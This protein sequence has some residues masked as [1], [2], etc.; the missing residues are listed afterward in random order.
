[1]ESVREKSDRVFAAAAAK[2]VQGQKEM[3][4]DHAAKHL[5][6]SGNTIVEAVRIYEVETAMGIDACADAVAKRLEG[7]GRAWGKAMD[8]VRDA[9]AAHTATGGKLVSSSTNIAAR[10]DPDRILTPLLGEANGRLEQRLRD[11]AEGWTSPKGRKW[12]DRHPLLYAVA[13]MVIG[14]IV[15]AAI[16]VVV[17]RMS[18][19]KSAPAAVASPAPNKGFHH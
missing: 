10:G 3:H 8:D 12:N 16:G 6:R 11:Y 14:S 18:M 19:A 4:A 13:M 7:R 5:L 17:A 15:T 1:M 2:I 9:L